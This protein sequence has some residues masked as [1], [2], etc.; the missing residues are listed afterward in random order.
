M[1]AFGG[2]RMSASRF[3]T[4]CGKGDAKKWK[5]S[6]WLEG[7]DGSQLQVWVCGLCVLHCLEVL[8]CWPMRAPCST[9]CGGQLTC[10][11]ARSPF[12]GLFPR[13]VDNGFGGGSSV[14]M[15]VNRSGLAIVGYCSTFRQYGE[16]TLR[17]LGVS[18]R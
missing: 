8:I 9:P 3:E 5:S 1:V 11:G 16:G 12:S 17:N 18:R 15:L 4:V 13:R 7:P 10:H 6:I 2:A 14:D